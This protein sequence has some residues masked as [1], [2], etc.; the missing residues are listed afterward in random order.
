MTLERDLALWDAGEL[1]RTELAARHPGEDV[2]SILSVFE[3]LSM[4]GSSEAGSDEDGWA[5]LR[6]R[7]PDRSAER[8]AGRERA[9]RHATRA[10]RM[11]RRPLI[12]AVAVVALSG[13]AAFAASPVVRTQVGHAVH[14]VTHLLGPASHQPQ[15]P[16]PAIT[17]PGAEPSGVAQSPTPSP[18][19]QP[20]EGGD[21][22]GH[23]GDGSTSDGGSGGGRGGSTEGSGSGGS[24]GTGGSD[25]SGSGG[26]D[27][28][29]SGGSGHDGPGGGSGDGTGGGGGGSGDQSSG[30]GGSQGGG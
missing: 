8:P 19:G 13:A 21:T 11:L 30:S 6:R 14:H 9:T 23:G 1:E 2:D 4:A 17:S 29:G 12:A 3:Q 28:S 24:D 5:A 25:G 7:L 22:N 16:D 20:G 18:T 27:G 10:G 26:S 15:Q